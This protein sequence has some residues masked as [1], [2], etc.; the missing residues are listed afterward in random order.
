MPSH[1]SD[2]TAIVIGKIALLGTNDTQDDAIEAGLVEM[3]TTLYALSYVARISPQDMAELTF[4]NVDTTEEWME[5]FAFLT[6]IIDRL[7]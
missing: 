1:S 3:M 2:F 6:T 4:K 7:A 5:Y